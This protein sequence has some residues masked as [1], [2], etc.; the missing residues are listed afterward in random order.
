MP[1]QKGAHWQGYDPDN[2]V[3][4]Q[5]IRYADNDISI[6][7]KQQSCFEPLQSVFA[8]KMPDETVLGECAFGNPKRLVYGTAWQTYPDECTR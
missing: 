8:I 1:G 4:T 7:A 3:R 6:V 2:I 5:D